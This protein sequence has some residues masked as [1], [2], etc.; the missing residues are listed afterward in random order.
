MKTAIVLFQL[1]G[2]DPIDAIGP[3]LFNLFAFS[4]TSSAS[5]TVYRAGNIEYVIPTRER[6]KILGCLWNSSLFPGRAH[7]GMVAVNAFV[8]GSRQPEMTQEND[9]SVLSATIEE[10][11]GAMQIQGKPVYLHMTRWDKS[12]PQYEIGYQGKMDA[13]SRFESENPGVTFAGNYRGGISVGDCVMNAR[14][15]AESIAVQFGRSV[16]KVS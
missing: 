3:S 15:I 1:G 8:G 9:E 4:K 6:R 14:R 16:S 7:D 5:R 10:L 13:L 2:P 12:I 11:R